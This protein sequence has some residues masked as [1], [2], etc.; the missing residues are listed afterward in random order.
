MDKNIYAGS[1]NI[2][3]NLMPQFWKLYY[4]K[5]FDE[6]KLEYLTETQNKETG[7]ALLLG[8]NG[9][10]II[11]HGSSSPKAI[12]NAI[13]RAQELSEKKI[14]DHIKEDIELNLSGVENSKE[15]IWKQIKNIAFGNEQIDDKEDSNPQVKNPESKET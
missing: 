6:Q 13:N 5:V 15:T 8:L 1:Y 7:G 9:V 2:P 11:A 4:K 12:K 14:I 10:V 3:E